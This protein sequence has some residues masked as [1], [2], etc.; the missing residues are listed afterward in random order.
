MRDFR[1]LEVWKEAHSFTL[2]IYKA[3]R[4]FPKE[5]LFALTSQMRRACI[6]IE[7][8]IAEGC[9]RATARDYAHFLQMAIGSA[10]EVDC[11]LLIA[12]DLGYIADA[13]VPA[14]SDK[15]DKIRRQL[16]KLLVKIR[17]G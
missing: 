13:N 14:L 2:V 5:E 15:I 4:D 6:S 1:Q 8:N 17:G 16:A 11:Q 3:T 9:G 12:K 10:F 7:S